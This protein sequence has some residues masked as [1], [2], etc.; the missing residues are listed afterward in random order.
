MHVVDPV[1]AAAVALF[2]LVLMTKFLDRQLTIPQ[3][4]IFLL[5][6]TFF[7]HLGSMIQDTHMAT[8]RRICD[9]FRIKT[10]PWTSFKNI[11]K[12]RNMTMTECDPWLEMENTI[13]IL[14]RSPIHICMDVLDQLLDL[15]GRIITSFLGMF[16]LQLNMLSYSQLIFLVPCSLTLFGIMVMA[17]RNGEIEIAGGAVRIMVWPR[18]QADLPNELA[19]IRRKLDDLQETLESPRGPCASEITPPK[20]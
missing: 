3:L 12:S 9:Q 13:W 14:S 2:L 5:V 4:L 18:S 7:W 16:F 20:L 8:W 6:L 11:F 10:G 19:R 17:F 15:P 1:L